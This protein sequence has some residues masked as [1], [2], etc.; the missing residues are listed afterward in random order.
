MINRRQFIGGLSLSG[1]TLPFLS[2]NEKVVSA[3]LKERAKSVIYIWLS[4]GMSQ[5]ETFNVDFNKQ[6]LGKSEPIKTNVDGMQISHYMP[7][8]AKH[9]DKMHVVN[10]VVTNQGAHP[11]AIYK[12]LT[13]YN[14]RSSITHPELGAW[15]SKLK[16]KESDTLPNFV[17]INSSRSGTSGFFPGMYAALP[18]RNPSAGI[19][20][21]SLHKQANPQKF[22]KR[23]GLL[24][25]LNNDFETE[26]GNKQTA[27]YSDVYQ[28][29]IKFM[30]SKDI[31]AFDIKKEDASIAKLYAKD[32]FSQGCLLA[33]RLAEKGVKF[34][35]IELGGW[36]Y[37]QQLY[38]NLPGNADKL[39]KG[40]SAL[41]QHLSLKGLL[42]T[43]LVVVAT[44]FG[45]KPEVNV[46]SGRDHHPK[47][48]T[49]LLAG[50]G[51]KAGEV[52]GKMSQDAKE[53]LKDPVD[54]TDFNATIAWAMG[55][56]PE[57]EVMS[58]SG[59]PFTLANKGKAQTSMFRG[60]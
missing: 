20:Y 6:T 40:L 52:T 55:I 21:S 27:A 28:N 58:S 35:K 34:S 30:K 11:A 8:M 36:D 43:T 53:I 33:A 17:G 56:K 31:E 4:G 5:Y 32:K 50:A 37:H 41:L 15:A 42:D 46:N 59:R 23:L 16:T 24:K 39:D 57:T 26:Y 10:S 45:R 60:V 49:C 22:D 14:P 47:G 25:R 2:A 9:M 19:K 51:V 7:N 1:G 38:T 44:E 3:P 54:I 13:S 29:S 48:Y 12:S 18:V